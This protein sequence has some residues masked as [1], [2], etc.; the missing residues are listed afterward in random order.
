[1]IVFL[2]S[3][4]YLGYLKEILWT[5]ALKYFS[6]IRYSFSLR[7]F[8]VVKQDQLASEPVLR[9]CY[10]ATKP[11]V[12]EWLWKS[13]ETVFIV[14]KLNKIFYIYLVIFVR[15]NVN[16]F[17]IIIVLKERIIPFD[18]QCLKLL[19]SQV[20]ISAWQRAFYFF[21]CHKG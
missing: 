10:A 17:K 15:I 13:W 4:K 6:I 14:T 21:S 7:Q 1:V 16:N 3:M 2:N 12:V 18:V 8:T 19:I 9:G 5:N 20:L 11:K